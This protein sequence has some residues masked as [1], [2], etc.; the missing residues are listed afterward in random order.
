MAG[1]SGLLEALS[2][3]P[4]FRRVA[5]RLRQ[6]EGCATPVPPGARPYLIAALCRELRR[7]MLVIASGPEAARDLVS[8]LQLWLEGEHT[9]LLL[10]E[11]DVFPYE[12]LLPD[13]ATAQQ[14]LRA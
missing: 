12:R 10:P 14:R 13:Q 6:G 5:E 3:A 4:A 1:L 9:P 11:S 7:P 2:S 8:Q